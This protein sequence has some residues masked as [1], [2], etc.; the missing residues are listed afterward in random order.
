MRRLDKKLIGETNA[1]IDKPQRK[2]RLD[3]NKDKNA[4]I[5]TWKPIRERSLLNEFLSITLMI[6]FDKLFLILYDN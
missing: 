1:L 4:K 6:L 3:N 2:N 5:T